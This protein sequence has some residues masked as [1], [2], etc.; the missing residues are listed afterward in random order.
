[1]NGI[2]RKMRR[3]FVICEPWAVVI[4]PFPFTEG[5]RSKRRPALAL[6]TKAFN[7]NGHT[8]LAMIT[9]KAHH[10]WPGDTDVDD[11]QLAG[12]KTPCIVRLK[13]FTLDNRLVVRQIGRLSDKD[14]NRTSE[15]IRLYLI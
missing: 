10:P 12:L 3:P 1:M 14:R 6:S 15:N 9:T 8:V 7:E 13:I 11:Y 5:P 4:V 2:V